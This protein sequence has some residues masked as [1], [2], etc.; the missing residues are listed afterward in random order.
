MKLPMSLRMILTA[1]LL[2]LL[3]GCGV[4]DFF[5]DHLSGTVKVDSKM[6]LSATLNKAR[7]REKANDW[8]GAEQIYRSA[9]NTHVGNKKLQRRYDNFKARRDDRVARLEVNRLIRQANS[10][11]R[12]H[13]QR[14]AKD[15]SYNGD[16]WREAVAIS[17]QLADKGLK[18]METKRLHLAER[19]LE[20]SLRVHSNHTTR[21]AYQRFTEYKERREFAELV[22]KGR[23]MADI[24]SEARM[25]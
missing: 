25:P 13:Y 1:L 16:H 4:N 3:G 24:S 5:R 15:P 20:M 6:S 19:A 21:S 17:K 18:A 7:A 2:S 14:K 8:Q 12:Q 11:K 22:R 10:L 23:K 9:L